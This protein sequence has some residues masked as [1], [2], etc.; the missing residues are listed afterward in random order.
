LSDP[1]PHSVVLF[2]DATGTRDGDIEQGKYIAAKGENSK[3][4]NFAR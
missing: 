1:Y 4:I 2:Y 3:K